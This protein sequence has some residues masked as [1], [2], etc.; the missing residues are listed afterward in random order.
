M[1]SLVCFLSIFFHNVLVYYRSR[2]GEFSRFTS[3]LSH[4]GV[5]ESHKKAGTQAPAFLFMKRY[6]FTK[7]SPRAISFFSVSSIPS[8]ACCSNALSV[9]ID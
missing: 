2:R 1:W 4:S 3:R 8:S 9:P 6:L 7:S 5:G